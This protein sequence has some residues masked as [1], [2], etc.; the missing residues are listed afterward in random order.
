[1]KRILLALLGCFMAFCPLILFGQIVIQNVSTNPTDVVRIVSNNPS[2]TIS[3]SGPIAINKTA[4]G[5]T[6]GG[7]DLNF[8]EISFALAVGNPNPNN[9]Y[10]INTH[11]QSVKLAGIIVASN[12]P[13]T[14][15]RAVGRWDITKK[16]TL[17]DG[18]VLAGTNT[19]DEFLYS[20]GESGLTISSDNNSYVVGRLF[21]KGAGQLTFPIGKDV[22]AGYLPARLEDVSAADANTPLG[23]EVKSGNATSVGFA[24]EPTVKEIFPD[25]FWE[26]TLGGSSFAGSNITLSDNLTSA[27]FVNDGD[28]V[29]L[30]KGLTS[31]QRSLGGRIGSGFIFS[32]APMAS[33]GKHYALAKADVISVIIYKLITPDKDGQN[34]ALYIQGIEAYPNNSVT[35]I[36]RWGV[37]AA[38]WKNFKNDDE[39]N[40]VDLAIGNYICVLKYINNGQEVNVKPQMITVLK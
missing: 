40:N 11:D 32:N 13:N 39:V 10:L 20:G 31:N 16:L 15:F 36:D 35:L 12:T 17:T 28:R 6:N 9:G 1:M 18:K 3:T 34:D 33:T 5:I 2:A 27:F 24:V 26:F 22:P 8:S 21:R 7:V 23:L 30:E 4:T 38:S 19:T 37:V 14:K 29:I 25:H